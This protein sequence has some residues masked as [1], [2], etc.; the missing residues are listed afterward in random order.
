M[1]AIRHAPVEIGY[2]YDANG[3]LRFIQ[4]GDANGIM[5]FDQQDL[6]AIAGGLFV[7]NHPPYDFPTGDPRHRA[8]SFSPKALVFMW[9]YDL[10][11]I[12]AVTI[13]RTYILRRPPGGFFLDPGQIREDYETELETIQARLADAAKAGSITNEEAISRG[14]WADEVMDVLG[15]LY[16]YWWMEVEP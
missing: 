9:E 5:G 8:G 12:V 16:D 11:A 3:Q 4:V 2:G 6:A 10:T 13:E 1:G 15:V 14:R 7:H